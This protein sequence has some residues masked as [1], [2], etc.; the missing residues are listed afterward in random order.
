MRRAVDVREPGMDGSDSQA[1]TAGRELLV[2]LSDRLTAVWDGQ[3][4]CG[5]GGTPDVVG[6]AWRAEFP[7]Q[8]VWPVGRRD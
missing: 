3:P 8:V 4:P 7:V 5:Y 6:Y 1:L 2:G